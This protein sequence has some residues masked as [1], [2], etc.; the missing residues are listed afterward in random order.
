M[1]KGSSMKTD[2]LT[3][4]ILDRTFQEFDSLLIS[5]NKFKNV[6][7]QKKST[8]D[9]GV[10]PILM[11]MIFF[12]IYQHSTKNNVEHA[13]LK[14]ILKEVEKELNKL[15]PGGAI[16]EYPEEIPRGSQKK[17]TLT[18]SKGDDTADVFKNVN[19]VIT[20]RIGYPTQFN[21]L[22]AALECQKGKSKISDSDNFSYKYLRLGL[23]ELKWSWGVTPPD[24]D[25]T[26]V[27]NVSV[28]KG[29]DKA[30]QNVRESIWPTFTAPRVVIVATDSVKSIIQDILKNGWFISFVS[31]MILLLVFQ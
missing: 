25:E 3:K 8:V 28:F 2:E 9:L 10:V 20:K 29:G 5:L 30:P 14:S 22:V 23:K 4:N 6:F 24:S 13:E 19:G 26:M 17:V 15:L 1:V 16:L 31:G 18:I 12:E 7:F 21:H 27:L 11:E